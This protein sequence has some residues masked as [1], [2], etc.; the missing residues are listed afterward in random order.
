MLALNTDAI[1]KYLVEKK[2]Q[3]QYQPET[4]QIYVNIK[5]E[6]SEFPLFIRAT[7]ES[8]LLQLIT[9]IPRNIK[10]SAVSDVARLL[11]LFNRELDLPG[12]G[13]NEQTGHIFYR[14][15]IPCTNRKFDPT[16]LE[17]FLS[18]V[19]IV[20]KNFAPSIVAVAD[21]AITFDDLLKKAEESETNKK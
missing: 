9:F 17:A 19:T 4:K 3:A 14:C 11:H 8:D 13:M 6:Q 16:I 18:S 2:F 1:L 21:G 7:D 20:C 5:I 12:F 15:I 10:P